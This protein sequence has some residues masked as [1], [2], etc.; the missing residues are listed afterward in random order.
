MTNKNNKEF[1]PN[2]NQLSYL[3]FI[4]D[5]DNKNSKKEIAKLI[6]IT[7]FAIY[8]WYRDKRF[9]DWINTYR[10]RLIDKSLL[11]IYKTASRKAR[12]GDFNYSRLLL[13]MS[14]NY[15]PRS[16]AKVTSIDKK[17]KLDNLS[18]KEIEAEFSKE[19]KKFRSTIKKES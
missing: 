2:N 7:E 19:L 15:T 6:G 13:E 11:E 9:V 16:E 4:L 8:K 10:T 17:D 5:L 18:D 14:G 1:I 12:A 3:E